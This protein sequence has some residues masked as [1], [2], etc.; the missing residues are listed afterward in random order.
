M[1]GT[2]GNRNKQDS[3]TQTTVT[4]VS[5]TSTLAS[6]SGTGDLPV[7]PGGISAGTTTLGDQGAGITGAASTT[8]PPGRPTEGVVGGRR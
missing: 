7:G 2:V 3:G 5:A 1:G 6:P 4:S 8:S